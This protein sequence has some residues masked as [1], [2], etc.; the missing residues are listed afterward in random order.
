MA[1]TF[2]SQYFGGAKNACA[3]APELLEIYRNIVVNKGTTVGEAF[4]TFG[5][6]NTSFIHRPEVR[7]YSPS[8]KSFYHTL[9]LFRKQWETFQESQPLPGCCRDHTFGLLG[10]D[11]QGRR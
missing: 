5:S 9:M 10:C 3:V 11:G 8:L 4:V 6:V 1:K 7:E 2:A